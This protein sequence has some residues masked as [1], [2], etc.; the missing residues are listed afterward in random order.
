LKKQKI[1]QKWLTY[2]MEYDNMSIK[3]GKKPLEEREKKP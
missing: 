1:F 2:N 3:R